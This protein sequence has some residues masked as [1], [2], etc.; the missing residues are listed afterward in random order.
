MVL[1]RKFSLKIMGIILLI[2]I[3]FVAYSIYQSRPQ[4]VIES[5]LNIE[6][7]AAS[8]IMKYDYYS[9]DIHFQTKIS[10]EEQSIDYMKKQLDNFF[11]GVTSEEN[12]NEMPSFKNTASWWDMDNDNIE[13]AY[14]NYVDVKK[15]RKI[16]P[17]RVW[18]FISKDK[19]DKYYLY[20]SY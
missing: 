9:N 20:I 10:I 7:P 11:G 12:I 19:G 1:K 17:R 14:M 6:L 18:A 2:G 3:I 15:W 5:R 8:K 16:M 13:A 4:H